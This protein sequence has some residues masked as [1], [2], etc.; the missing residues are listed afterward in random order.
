MI[1]YIIYNRIN[2]KVYVGKTEKTLEERWK[3][4]LATAFN[5]KSQYAIH[6]ALRKYGVDA[7]TITR[8][9][10]AFSPDQLNDL[11]VHFIQRFQS[12]NPKFGYNMAPGGEGGW[13]FVNQLNKINHPRGMK[14]KKHSS[15]TRK[16][17]ALP[18][19]SIQGAGHPMFG[20]H[21]T[22]ESVALTSASVKAAR[23]KRFWSTRKKT[24]NTI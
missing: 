10:D 3:A 5:C 17:M 14:G 8:L 13:S 23:Q 2:H 6:R 4:H 11:E 9:S 21:H 12:M 18:R 16:K 1:I 20:L 15:Q 24:S 22:P 19:P 7:F